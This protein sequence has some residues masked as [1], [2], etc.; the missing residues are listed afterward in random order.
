MTMLSHIRMAEASLT[1][2][3]LTVQRTTNVITGSHILGSTGSVQIS[4]HYK[5]IIWQV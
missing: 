5:P 4:R 3:N 1:L 2:L